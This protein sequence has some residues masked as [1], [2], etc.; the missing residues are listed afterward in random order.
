[1]GSEI[2]A[3]IISKDEDLLMPPSGE[4]L[5]KE[6]IDVIGKWIQHGANWKTVQHSVNLNLPPLYIHLP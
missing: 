4:H 5:S 2:V 6:Q 3:R 1:M